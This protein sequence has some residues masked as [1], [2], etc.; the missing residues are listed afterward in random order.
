MYPYFQ[1]HISSCSATNRSWATNRQR[2]KTRPRRHKYEEL[3]LL[4][5][6]LW[7]GPFEVDLCFDACGRLRSTPAPSVGIEGI[8]EA[9]VAPA[10]LAALTGVSAGNISGAFSKALGSVDIEG[11]RATVAAPPFEAASKCVAPLIA[12]WSGALAPLIFGLVLNGSSSMISVKLRATPTLP[13]A[14]GSD[15][16]DSVGVASNIRSGGWTFPLNLWSQ[17][18]D[19]EKALVSKYRKSTVAYGEARHN[20]E[21]KH[22]AVD[23]L[24]DFQ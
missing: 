12:V 7:E 24:A 15:I 21:A 13:L 9:V 19:E 6:R 17:L 18:E 16:G 1:V 5:P 10:T 11:A 3:P 23:N 8:W 4:D 20:K 14:T 22:R 2:R